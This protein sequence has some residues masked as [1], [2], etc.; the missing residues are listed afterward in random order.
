MPLDFFYGCV[1][2]NPI[3]KIYSTRI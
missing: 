1:I 3:W 2:I